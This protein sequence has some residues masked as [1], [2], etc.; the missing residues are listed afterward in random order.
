[1][2]KLPACFAAAAGGR[3]RI[4]RKSLSITLAA[5]IHAPLVLAILNRAAM[6]A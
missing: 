1:M 4:T 3:A 6:F 5:M 2:N